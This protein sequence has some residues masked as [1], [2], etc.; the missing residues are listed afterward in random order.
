MFACCFVLLEPAIPAPGC[1]CSGPAQLND[2]SSE[3]SSVICSTDVKADLHVAVH[4]RY[5]LHELADM[6]LEGVI[7][8][9]QRCGTHP[10]PCCLP[11]CMLQGI[12]AGARVKH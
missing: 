4:V 2:G 9:C 1:V 8:C 7:L 12:S 5:L 11:R 10:Q 3:H 6:C